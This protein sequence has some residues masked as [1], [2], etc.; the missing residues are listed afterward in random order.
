MNQVVLLLLSFQFE[1][2]DRVWY[3]LL[4]PKQSISLLPYNHESTYHAYQPC[5]SMISHSI[6][7]LHQQVFSLLLHLWFQDYGQPL[8]SM[9]HLKGIDTWVNYQLWL[10][11]C[12]GILVK[13]VVNKLYSS[14]TYST[15]LRICL[16]IKGLR[17]FKVTISNLCFSNS[18]SKMSQTDRK[19]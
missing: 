6:Y 8:F 9:P 10:N 13:Y 5:V 4:H 16:P 15:S 2:L 1:G 11:L 18:S 19:F 12:T 7:I 17:P 14:Y 3:F